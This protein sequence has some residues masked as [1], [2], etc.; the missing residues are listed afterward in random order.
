MFWW[1]AS[2]SMWTYLLGPSKMVKYVKVKAENI[3]LL[4]SMSKE[5]LNSNGCVPYLGV[6]FVVYDHHKKFSGSVGIV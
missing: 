2:L 4:F 1:M 3:K 5:S 6:L